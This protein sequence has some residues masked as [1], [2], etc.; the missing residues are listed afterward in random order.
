LW[1]SLLIRQSSSRLLRLP[2]GLLMN[3]P[4]D[5]QSASG[6][7]MLKIAWGAR[8]S[9][10]STRTWEWWLCYRTSGLTSTSKCLA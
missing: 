6:L 9:A 5:V 1:R 4:G 7:V 10:L 8:R 3:N 2:H